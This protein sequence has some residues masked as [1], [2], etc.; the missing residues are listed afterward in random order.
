MCTKR[1]ALECS[2]TPKLE[3]IQVPFDIQIDHY[4]IV[5]PHCNIIQPK[6]ANYSLLAK[7]SSMPVLLLAL[8]LGMDFIVLRSC[9]NNSNKEDYVSETKCDLQSL[10]YLMSGLFQ[11]KFANLESNKENEQTITT[12]NNMGGFTSNM[13]KERSYIHKVDLPYKHKQNQPIILEVR[14]VV[15]LIENSN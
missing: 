2:K 3:T 5:Y 12:S 9:K 14:L 6:L 1:H 8:E 13:L 10:K 7:F 11:K 15:T 4:I